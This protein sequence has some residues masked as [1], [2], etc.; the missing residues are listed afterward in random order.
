MEREE[1]PQTLESGVP[2]FLLSSGKVLLCTNDTIME[3]FS[4][5]VAVVLGFEEICRKDFNRGDRTSLP[6]HWL[7]KKRY[8]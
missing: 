4:E 2:F 6:F 7:G 3:D 5:E 1:E 8:R